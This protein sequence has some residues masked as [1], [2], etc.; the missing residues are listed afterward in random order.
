MHE[1][2]VLR[3]DAAEACAGGQNVLDARDRRAHRLA[4]AVHTWDRFDEG[5]TI[6]PPALRRCHAG[7]ALD[8]AQTLSHLGRLVSGRQD[9]ER[10]H[11]S[12]RDARVREHLASGDRIALSGE[13]LG[14]SL[15]R[16]E[17]ESEREQHADDHG[18]YGGHRKRPADDETRPL[19][20]PAQFGVGD[21][22]EALGHHSQLVDAV[23]EQREQRR[24]E[25][26]RD[27]HRHR[28]N[29]HAADSDRPDERQREQDHAQQSDCDRR[30]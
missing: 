9:D 2:A 24:E 15:A 23:P 18:A 6:L 19:T 30:A 20:P 1:V 16:I 8:S 4:G 11:H 12:R 29:Q 14:L 13:V 25:R 5:E 28:R 17:L 3:R 10:L 7:D 27:D 26:D 21:G 22:D